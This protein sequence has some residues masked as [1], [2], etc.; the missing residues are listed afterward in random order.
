[1]KKSFLYI[2]AIMIFPLAM[3]TA[4][5]L[6]PNY[7]SASGLLPAAG[8][9]FHN[10]LYGLD[11]PAWL[12][13]VRTPESALIYQADAANADHG[14]FGVFTAAP[15]IGAS[16]LQTK[17][18]AG[19]VND[20][21]F[22]FAGGNRTLSVGA[23]YQWSSGNRNAYRRMDMIAAGAFLRPNEYLS[24]GVSGRTVTRGDA[25]QGVVDVGIRPFGTPLVALFGDFSID[26][27]QTVSNGNWSAGAL[28]EPFD[29][30]RFAAR[31][32]DTQAF[33][34][35]VNISFGALGAGMHPGFDKNSKSVSTT[36]MLRVDGYDR[37]IFRSS[38]RGGDNLVK[39]TMDK[40]V[41]HTKGTFFSQKQSLTDLLQEIEY[42]KNDPAVSGIVINTTTL[43]GGRTL[44]WEVREKLKEFRAS[45]KKI[46]M[47]IERGG[48]DTYHFASV[49]DYI[50]ME[51]IGNL[52]LGGYLMGRSYLKGTLEKIGI[53]Y[54][55][56][57]FF[58]YKSAMESLS[59]ENMSDADRE[60]RQALVDDMYAV[61]KKDISE[62]RGMSGER[63]DALVDSRIVLTAEDALKEGLVDTL[64]RWTAIDDVLKNYL[65][66][67][68]SYAKKGTL[69]GDM[70]PYATW[71]E[72]PQIA[73]IYA[74]GA[75]AMDDGIR[76]RE[77][78]KSV[79]A[80]VKN[81]KIKAIVLRVDS[82]G[83]DAMASDY[84]SEVL[85]G[86]K[87][88]KPIIISQADVAAS[89]GYWLSMYSD[90]IVAAPN[91]ITGSIGVIGGWLY[92]KGFK[93]SI[94]GS[95]DMV[96][97]GKYADLGF[98][99]TL[100]LIGLT[101]PDRPMTETERGMMETMI[102][103]YYNDFVTKVAEGRGKSY[104]EIEKVAQG[105]V[106]SG[107]DG[108]E[109]GLVDHIGGIE[110]AIALAKE[111]AGIAKEKEISVKEY[112]VQP[113]FNIGDLLSLF[114][115]VKETVEEDPSVKQI[116]FRLEHNGRP[117]PMLPLDDMEIISR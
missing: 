56:F 68:K 113:Y 77:L 15:G 116:K 39:N 23:G 105:R 41:S 76:A 19:V 80:A 25:S 1:M 83:G 85:K 35:G 75:C 3:L 4:Q 88:K 96:K 104:E 78:E 86:A 55:E 28:V 43:S 58:K 81:S 103:G 108:K 59:R 73:V 107:L 101:I 20:Y 38:F 51:P 82:P 60:Q 29:G 64:A 42:A 30:I 63:F 70:M 102:R 110:L 72:P 36:Y 84:V 115:G 40:P 97:A 2:T 69:E 74:L 47:Y 5:P 24:V 94:G 44:L 46:V 50:V 22:A 65:G 98:G 8:G 112:I 62:G 79:T 31:Y 90:A 37:N 11:N 33:S 7:H 26:N 109:I 52:A 32:Y 67:K 34:I 53:G 54:D 92:D 99:F 49:A 9:V 71:S 117:L 106:W 89:G 45:G 48:I 95:T 12:T 114:N 13:N 16:V 57:R 61:A 6:I 91:T 66:E 93:A 18:A 10:G 111:K 14:S 27:T 17:T 87:G 21:S 100:P